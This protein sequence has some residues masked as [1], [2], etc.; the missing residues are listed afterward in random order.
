LSLSTNIDLA[1]EGGGNEDSFGTIVDPLP[2]PPVSYRL[3]NAL[4]LAG[5]FLARFM[6]F[7]FILDSELQGGPLGGTSGRRPAMAS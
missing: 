7:V 6:T 3:T 5:R 2:L 1:V 4:R